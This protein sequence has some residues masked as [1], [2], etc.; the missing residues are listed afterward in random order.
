MCPCA[1]TETKAGNDRTLHCLL[2]SPV[3]L[4]PAVGELQAR[5]SSRPGVSWTRDLS[6]RSTADGRRANDS[7][8]G[9]TVA[10][11]VLA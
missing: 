4:L 3:S 9:I 8:A 10:V 1:K 5:S 6:S 11:E 2:S 7:P